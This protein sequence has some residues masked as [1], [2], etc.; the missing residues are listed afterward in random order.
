VI[1][2]AEGKNEKPI[3]NVKEKVSTNPFEVKIN[4]KTFDIRGRKL[5]EENGLLGV[6]W[7]KAVKKVIIFL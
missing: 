3:L 5:K 7:Q 2:V 6:A 1:K 4:R